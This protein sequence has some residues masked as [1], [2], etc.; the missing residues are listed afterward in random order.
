MVKNRV[1]WFES[2]KIGICLAP[3][4]DM[5]Q[6]Y[7]SMRFSAGEKSPLCGGKARE[8]DVG[9]VKFWTSLYSRLRMLSMFITP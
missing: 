1:P 8:K 7:T 4:D 3:E 2:R 9:N 5:F 6:V